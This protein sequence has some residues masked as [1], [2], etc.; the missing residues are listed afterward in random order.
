MQTAEQLE[1]ARLS[2]IAKLKARRHPPE[3]IIKMKAAAKKRGVSAAARLARLEKQRK[4]LV[5]IETDTV[6]RDAAEAAM[7]H[8]LKR[9][10]VY[11]V[12]FKGRVSRTALVSFRHALPHEIGK[13]NARE[14]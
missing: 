10:H 2:R 12:L 8:G 13:A 3:T 14:A 1:A 6:F 7:A 4:Y 9:S 5:C 11:D